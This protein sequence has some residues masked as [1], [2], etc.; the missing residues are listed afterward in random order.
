[1]ENANGTRLVID[2]GPGVGIEEILKRFAEQESRC[3]V[4][5]AEIAKSMIDAGVVSSEREAARH[6]A[7]EIGDQPETVLQ[8]INR[9]KKAMMTPVITSPTAQEKSKK[10]NLEKLE[11]QKHGGARD[12]AGRPPLATEAMQF[13]VIAISQLE[14]IRKADPKRVEALNRVAGWIENQLKS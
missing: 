7:T 14:R 13:A 10:Y 11:K 12:G 3:K 5:T 8:R 6:I 9:G 1:M 2:C 4:R